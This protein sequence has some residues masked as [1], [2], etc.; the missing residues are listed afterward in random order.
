MV[1]FFLHSTSVGSMGGLRPSQIRWHQ[2]TSPDV[3]LDIIDFHYC[4]TRIAP[5]K[6]TRAQL[7]LQ[8]PAGC[9]PKP[10]AIA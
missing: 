5:N 7:Q 3:V 2:K 1:F 10:A 6:K 9:W 8:L 4:V